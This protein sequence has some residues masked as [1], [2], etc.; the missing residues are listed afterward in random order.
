MNIFN[1]TL[2]N[3]G[4][5]KVGEFTNGIL[6]DKNAVA[7]IYNNILV[8]CRNGINVTKKADYAN[9]MV[10]NNLVYAIDDSL[11]CKCISGSDYSFS[12]RYYRFRNN[13]HAVLFSQTR[14]QLL[15]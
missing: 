13:M 4:W 10:G 12:Y 14:I 8:G 9:C 6:I 7:N 11:G 1:N 15:M 2:I 3:G 5:R